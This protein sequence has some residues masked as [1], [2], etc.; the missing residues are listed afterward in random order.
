VVPIG[1]LATVDADLLLQTTSVGMHPNVD[2]SVV[3]ASALRPGLVVYDAVYNP[4]ETRLLREAR[5]AGCVCVSGLGHFINQAALQFELWTGRRAPRD[6][7]RG[8]LLRRL[9]QR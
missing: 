5:Q 7:M 3:P 8:E 2:E 9:G 1:E 6:I 4:L